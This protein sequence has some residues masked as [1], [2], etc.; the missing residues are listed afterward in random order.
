MSTNKV[1]FNITKNI[2]LVLKMRNP[3]QVFPSLLSN[4]KRELEKRIMKM[5]FTKIEWKFPD[6]G[7]IKYNIDGAS[8]MHSV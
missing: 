6:M 3:R 4:I 7:W 2:G 5:K 1:M 8:R